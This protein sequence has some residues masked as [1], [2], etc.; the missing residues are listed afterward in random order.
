MARTE[1]TGSQIKDQS[2]DL[3]VDVTNILPVGNGG[4]GSNTL[5]LN[6]VLI[7][8]GTGALQAIAPGTAGNVLRSNG[9]AWAST[10][11]TKSDVGLANV[12]NT[13]DATKN[14]ATATLTNK[15]LS[16]PVLSGTVTGTYTLGGTPTFPATVVQTTSTQTLTNK[17]ISGASNT[18]TNIPVSALSTTGVAGS[19]TYLRGDGTWAA[20]TADWSTLTNKPAYIAAGATKAAARTAIDAE[21]TGNKGQPGGYASLDSSG[22]IPLSQWGAQ[23]VDGGTASTSTTDIID[24]GS[25]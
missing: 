1:V 6:N 12:D 8:N 16:A 7:G 2:V 11:L 18:L 24:G 14:S 9:S 20:V 22:Y 15:T 19:S 4:T 5:P 25:A 3:T 23:V 17:T 13:S 10:A 21:F